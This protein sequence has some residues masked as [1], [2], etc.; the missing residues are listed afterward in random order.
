MA[1]SIFGEM[2]LWNDSNTTL[3][4]LVIR[5]S[6]HPLGSPL[7]FTCISDVSVGI[8]A[9]NNTQMHYAS[10]LK[11]NTLQEQTYDVRH[12]KLSLLIS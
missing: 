5:S 11:L 10:L 7:K 4:L 2:C 1:L 9:D 3:R 6:I 8:A 12:K